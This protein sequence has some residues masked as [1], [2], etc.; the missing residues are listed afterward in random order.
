MKTLYL[1]Q[2]GEISTADDFDA[3]IASSCESVY[4]LA[5]TADEASVLATEYDLGRIQPDNA[6]WRGQTVVA[7]QA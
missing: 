4:A 1:I 3:D 5:E 2:S 6:A 7:L